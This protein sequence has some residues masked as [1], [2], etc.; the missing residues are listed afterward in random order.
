MSSLVQIEANYATALAGHRALVD[1]LIDNVV[2]II[3]RE[4][5]L[6][7]PNMKGVQSFA[8]F[9]LNLPLVAFRHPVAAP[10]VGGDWES[11]I[12]TRLREIV[13]A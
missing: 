7:N 6:M 13:A 1:A 11:R 9:D 10:S 2:E 4:R 5:V 3:A 8:S 12:A